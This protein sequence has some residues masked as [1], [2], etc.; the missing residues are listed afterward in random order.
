MSYYVRR[1]EESNAISC[2]GALNELQRVFSLSGVF[3]A[4]LALALIHAPAVEIW[5][6]QPCVNV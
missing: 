1:H 6:S 2:R 3:A 4:V 5:S